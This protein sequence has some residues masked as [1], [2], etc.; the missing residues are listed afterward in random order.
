VA[1][2]DGTV[3]HYDLYD[4]TSRSLI[5]IVPGFWRD[6]RHQAIVRMA[7]V[8]HGLG[9]RVAA[10]DVRGHG[11]SGG[12][13]GFNLHE[14][15]DVAAVA[16]D[17]LAKLAIESITLIGLS[18]GGAISISTAARHDLPIGAVLLISPVADFAMIMP[19]INPFT[20]HRHIAV[21]QA[22]KKPR[23]EWRMRKSAKLR[24]IDDVKDVHVPIS[25]IHVKNDWLV[26]HD[27][28][29]ALYE[30]ANE[31]KEL[32][33]LDVEGNYHADRIFSVAK[34]SIEPVVFEFLEKF[35]PK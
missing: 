6:R 3:I 20:I 12:T 13:Y 4:N 17:L 29:V 9:Y 18:Y 33:I 28:S 15:Y 26:G 25:L 5:L 11:D 2:F 27:H 24:A 34:D 14:H 21:S 10:V 30:N 19:R 8:L 1:A 23:F 16:R 31:P 35:T 32:H 7:A 22:M